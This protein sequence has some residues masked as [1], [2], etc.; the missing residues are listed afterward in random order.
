MGVL[1]VTPSWEQTNAV[2]LQRMINILEPDVTAIAT[3]GAPTDQWQSRIPVLSLDSESEVLARK[4]VYRLGIPVDLLSKTKAAQVLRK[5]LKSD[6]VDCV[7][8][9]FADFALK[10]EQVWRTATKPIFVHCH[11]YDVTWDLRSYE[12]PEQKYFDDNYVASIKRLSDCVTFIANS[13]CTRQRLLDIG[14]A[15]ERVVVKY[16]G[17]PVPDQPISRPDRELVEILYL[18]RFVDLQRA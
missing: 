8:V 2:W 3:F 7:L 16:L 4:V 5:S 15:E 14:V 18:G 11:G 10:F 13:Q 12:K 1:V 17:T 9:H 6:S